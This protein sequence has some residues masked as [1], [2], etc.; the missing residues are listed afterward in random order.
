M[1]KLSSLVALTALAGLAAFSS[2]CGIVASPVVGG[3][4]NGSQA[5]QSATSNNIGP[6]KGESC[7]SSILGLIA[8]GD[9]SAASA[10]AAGGITK[11]SVVDTEVMSILGIYGKYCTVVHGE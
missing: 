7:A 10:A 3:I 4:Y 1:N 2:G 8:M 5:H 11:I 9:A 6:K